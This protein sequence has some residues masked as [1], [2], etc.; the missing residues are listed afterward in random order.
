MWI[1]HQNRGISLG[2]LGRYDEAEKELREAIRRFSGAGGEFQETEVAP[3]IEAATGRTTLRS[4][5]K[6]VKT[7]TYYELANLK[8]Y[9][10]SEDFDALL[11][12]ADKQPYSADAALVA[13]DWAWLQMEK[14]KEDYGALVAQGA[15]WERAGFK[16]WA[17]EYYQRFERAHK[18]IKDKRYEDLRR[19]VTRQLATLEGVGQ[20][21]RLEASVAMLVFQS[22]ELSARNKLDEALEAINE[23]IKKAGDDA[24]LRVDRAAILFQK[25]DYR[26]C[27]ADCA[28]IL[29]KVRDFWLAYYWRAVANTN[30]KEEDPE[31]VVKDLQNALKYNPGHGP[32]MILLSDALYE[33][34]EN[35]GFEG[36]GRELDQAL[37]LL[38]RSISA[39]DVPADDLP[40]IYYKIAR[41][42]CA[43]EDFKQAIKPLETAIVIKDDDSTF[44]ELWRNA[45]KGLGKNDGQVSCSLASVH[46]QV[47]ETKLRLGKSGKALDACWLGLEELIGDEKQVNKAEVKQEIAKTMAEMS[48]IIE[49]VGSRAKATEFWQSIA[50]LE[51]MKL[52]RGGAKAELGHLAVPP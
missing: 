9:A 42:Q 26:G 32:S 41:V 36:S 45:Q 11:T 1:A 3:D 33:R 7:A 13:L 15:L 48:Q 18:E 31:E 52:L 16:E 49:S 23:A 27:K 21:L 39:E 51:N 30:L 50:K 40:Y 12:A 37:Q 20:P 46:R 47:A 5:E 25:E 38:E 44:Y 8:A 28:Q 17:K 6:V 2:M 4:D 10:G 43:R 34:A 29:S 19:W 35:E 22:Q 14:R 24:M